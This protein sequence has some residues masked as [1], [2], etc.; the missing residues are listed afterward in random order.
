M[1]ILGLLSTYG[2]TFAISVFITFFTA[3]VKDRVPKKV[4]PYLAPM[5]ALITAPF[6]PLFLPT[7]PMSAVLWIKESAI[8][9]CREWILSVLT[10]DMIIRL[11][12]KNEESEE[13]S[14]GN[15]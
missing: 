15:E 12:R 14:D 3:I 11:F 10:Y 8:E 1:D 13:V 6:T 5:F 4:V 2:V 9:W 7:V